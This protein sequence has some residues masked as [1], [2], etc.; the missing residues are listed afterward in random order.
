MRAVVAAPIAAAAYAAPARRGGIL[1]G[2]AA[3]L[4]F[5]AALAVLGWM[6]L[7]PALA[8][9]R[10]ATATGAELRLDGLMADPFGGRATVSGWAVRASAAPKAPQL[11]HGGASSAA[12][13]A[14]PTLLAA[15][16]GESVV[17]DEVTLDV[18]TLTLAPDAKGQWPLLA[19]AAASGLPYECGGPIG[20]EAP[21]V[22]IKLLRLKVAALVVRDAA[23]KRDVSVPIAWKGE[24]RDFDH[25]RPLV[26]ALLAAVA[27]KTRPATD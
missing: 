9:E 12:T 7:A 14:W 17:V 15:S 2:L 13:A 8:Q 20:P 24:F 6:L 10:F 11:A 22:K 19:L 26:S 18:T 5:A 3:A 23:S 25:T 27:Q 4:V 16:A 21:R 1:A